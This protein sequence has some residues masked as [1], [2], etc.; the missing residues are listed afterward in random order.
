MMVLAR[1]FAVVGLTVFIVFDVATLVA[2]K[3]GYQERFWSTG[4]PAWILANIT[5][6]YAVYWIATGELL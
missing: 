2:V 4:L 3:Q 5:L 1:L 6:A